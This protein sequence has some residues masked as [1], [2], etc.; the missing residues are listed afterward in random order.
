M[1][2]PTFLFVLYLSSFVAGQGQ[3]TEKCLD[4]GLDWYTGKVGETPCKTYE[5]LRQ[6][7]NTNFRVGTMNPNTP[8]DICNEQVA[9][10]CCNNIAF[11]LSMLCLTCQKGGTGFDAGIGAY[12]I[13]L[14]GDRQTGFCN[15]QT[16][17]TLPADI[18][19]A[20]CNEKINIYDDLYN[21]FWSDGSWFY[22]YTSQAITK[23]QIAKPDKVFT[24]CPQNAVVVP[25]PVT[26]SSSTT[27]TSTSSTNVISSS[28]STTSTT[29][30]GSKVSSS[31]TASGTTSTTSTSSTN[32]KSSSSSASTTSSTSSTGNGNVNIPSGSGIS[33][34]TDTTTDSKGSLGSGAIAGIAIG[35]V[36]AVVAAALAL[37]L[38][39]R[40][41]RRIE[42]RSPPAPEPYGYAQVKANGSEH[43]TPITSQPLQQYPLTNATS[44]THNPHL[45]GLPGKAGMADVS[46]E[47][48]EYI[49]PRPTDRVDSESGNTDLLEMSERHVDAG[50]L[51]G[52]GLE[53]NASGRLP[54]AYGDLIRD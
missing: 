4:A 6:I 37:C 34:N 19:S 13:Y 12:Q 3:G 50:P 48:T 42:R 54:P 16:N 33:S 2:V 40:R 10:C 52:M 25:P 53:R 49:P 36:V 39:I 38:W 11:A 29:S 5:R 43:H 8:P 23:D 27:T 44:S 18:Q 41:K 32:T 28:T 15:A 7:C 14:T 1:S 9:D 47:N 20:V 17:N 31:S 21:I 35:S 26:T 22:I 51:A 30:S 45:A 46:L 24:K